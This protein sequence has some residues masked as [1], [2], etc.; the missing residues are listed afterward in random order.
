MCLFC[1][2]FDKLQTKEF[3]IQNVA[4]PKFRTG[5]TYGES[6]PFKIYVNIQ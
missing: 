2:C 4:V 5:R 1:L 3:G 6:N